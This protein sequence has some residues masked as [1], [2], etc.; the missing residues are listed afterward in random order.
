[1]ARAESRRLGQARSFGI[2]GLH[3]RAKTAGRWVDI[4]SNPDGTTL[5][6]SVPLSGPENGF[7]DP[8]MPLT[9]EPAAETDPDDPTKWG[10]L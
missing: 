3:E 10:T 2:R 8:L 7:I 4:S 9:G 5:I 6:L 1:M